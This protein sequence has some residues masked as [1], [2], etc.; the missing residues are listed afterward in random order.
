[1]RAHS[2]RLKLTLELGKRAR[3]LLAPC[4]MCCGLEL[5]AEFRVRQAERFCAPQLLGVTIP[6]RHR[7][8]RALFF[9]L[10]HPFLDAVLC[11]DKSF[12][13]VCHLHLLVLSFCYSLHGISYKLSGYQ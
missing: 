2:K 6:L 13:C 1:V 11:V 12:T 5:T 7:A 3:Q 4:G 8:S 9:P 10:V